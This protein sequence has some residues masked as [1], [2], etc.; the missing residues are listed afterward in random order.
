[1]KAVEAGDAAAKPPKHCKVDEEDYRAGLQLDAD[2]P[3]EERIKNFGL[4][5]EAVSMNEEAWSSCAVSSLDKKW[6]EAGTAPRGR[7]TSPKERSGGTMKPVPTEVPVEEVLVANG[8][9]MMGCAVVR[10]SGKG[11]VPVGVERAATE[12]EQADCCQRWEARSE[13]LSV[14]LA[15]DHLQEQLW[16]A[17][18]RRHQ[19]SVVDLWDVRR[20]RLWAANV[21]SGEPAGVQSKATWIL[22]EWSAERE[23]KFGAGHQGGATGTGSRS[24]PKT[25]AW[26]GAPR[27]VESRVLDLSV[28]VLQPAQ[29]LKVT[30]REVQGGSVA[31]I[32]SDTAAE[33]KLPVCCG[34]AQLRVRWD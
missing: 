6:R 30:V 31:L 3:E 23:M 11:L 2:G 13:L 33:W 7:R 12:A 17:D 10:P 26:T 24:E 25:N 27:R 16:A 19:L 4:C 1:M 34:A 29:W 9:A 8:Q 21:G 15:R 32:D 18:L 22:Q 5:E 14:G 20:Q 28:L